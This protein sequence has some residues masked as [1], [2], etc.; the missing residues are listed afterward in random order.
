MSDTRLNPVLAVLVRLLLRPRAF[1][2]DPSKK[3][4]ILSEP[5]IVISNHTCHLDGPILNTVLLP[6]IMHTLAAKDRF[7]QRGFGFF[8]RHTGCI[9]I[10]RE[11]ADTSW[12]HESLRFLKTEKENIVIYPEGRHGE[13]RKQLPF[14]PAVLTLAALARVPIVMVYQDGPARWFHRNELLIAPPF[15]LPEGALTAEY[16]K[17][18]TAFLQETMKGLMDT[19]IALRNPSD[20]AQ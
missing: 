15:R 19:Y 13:H 9:P 8:L 12:L 3:E 1:Y 20:D 11:R 4:E 17:E 16:V 6:K 5:S 2:V 7:E 10:D 18:Q 14:H